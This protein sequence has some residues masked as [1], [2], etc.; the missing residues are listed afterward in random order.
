MGCGGTC[1]TCRPYAEDQARRRSGMPVRP[2][3]P[4]STSERPA[5]D[6]RYS[7]LPP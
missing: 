1:P 7:W 2:R 6:P 4:E 3:P 5:K